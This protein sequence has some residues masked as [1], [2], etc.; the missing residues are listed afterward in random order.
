METTPI[1]NT[2]TSIS[3]AGRSQSASWIRG[4]V[5]TALFAALF[6]AFSF[7]KIPLGF[8]SVPITLQTFAVMLAGGLLGSFYGFLSIMIVL[9]LTATGLPLLGGYGGI[10]VIFGATGGFIWMFP[11]SALLIGFAS[12]RL[13]ARTKKLNRTG[14]AWLFVSLVLFSVVL[15][16]VGGVPWY[17]FK[18]KLSFNAAMVGGCYPFL[19][20]DFV[21]AIAAT[22]LISTLRPMLARLR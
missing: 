19:F 14:I 22:A 15:A 5:F 7:A 2:Q 16:Y 18:A 1:S 12:D 8:S 20:G 21:K 13:F 10:S 6:V 17:A 3:A 4:A 9:L 11:I